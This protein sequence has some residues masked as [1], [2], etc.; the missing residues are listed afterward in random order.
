M[1]LAMSGDIVEELRDMIRSEFSHR[2]DD[3]RRFVDRRIAELSMEVSGAVQ[4]MDYSEANIIGQL[5]RVHD[6]IACMIAAPVSATRNSGLELEA[7]VQT[8]EAAASRIMEAAEAISDWLRGGSRDPAALRSIDQRI[9]SIFEACSFQ[10]LTG[11]RIRRAIANLQQVDTMLGGMIGN[12]AA[13]AAPVPIEPH[14]PPADGPDLAQQ[15][16]DRLMCDF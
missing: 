16:I 8:T 10:D 4:I 6:Q 15:E 3:L 7:V 12:A 5:A 2:F 13:S 9:N 14:M 11:Q 1:E